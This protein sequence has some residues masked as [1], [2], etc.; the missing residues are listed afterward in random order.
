MWVGLGSGVRVGA[1]PGPVGSEAKKG[2]RRSGPQIFARAGL[3]RAAAAPA[4]SIQWSRPRAPQPPAR[5][6]AQARGADGC[7]RRQHL[8]ALLHP[9]DPQQER[10]ARRAGD[11][12]AL[13]TR[14]HSGGS[15]FGARCL[16]LA[17]LGETDAGAL[18]AL[19]PCWRRLRG[20]RT[21]AGRTAESPGG[22]DSDRALSEENEGGRRWARTPA[23]PAA[24]AVQ[25]RP[26]A[27]ASRS[28][29]CPLPRTW[30]RKLQARATVRCRPASQVRARLRW[31]RGLG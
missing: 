22:W 20:T 2:Q 16:L 14:G 11:R 29:S 3:T 6:A 7:A 24:P 10:G 23:G 31:E 4:R 5:P 8:D 27:S 25:A 28:A 26:W 30:R 9:G 21:A 1:D 19:R 18:G 13:G 12:G 17:A 15:G